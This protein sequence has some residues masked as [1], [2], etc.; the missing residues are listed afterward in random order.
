[1]VVAPSLTG[2]K[3]SDGTT[4]GAGG[5]GATGGGPGTG[6]A[7]GLAS[8]GAGHGGSGSAGSGGAAATG[9]SGAGSGNGGAGGGPVRDC[10]PPCIANLRKAC[11]RPSLD[12]GTCG[13]GNGGYC[14]SNGILES[15]SLVDGGALVT[16]TEPDGHTPCYLVLSN[17]AS[18]EARYETPDGQLVAVVTADGS[19]YTVTCDGT[20]TTVDTSN[21][22]CAMLTEGACKSQNACPP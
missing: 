6:G 16:F 18:S 4:S 17:L 8:A 20:T 19:D 14:Y 5:G 12:G 1:M 2:C 10:F 22:A 21:P 9:G 3:G 11:E 13:V 7:G 15:Q